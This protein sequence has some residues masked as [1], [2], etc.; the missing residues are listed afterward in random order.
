MVSVS[1]KANEKVIGHVA[2][3]QQPIIL[4]SKPRDSKAWAQ[5]KHGKAMKNKPNLIYQYQPA[6]R[7]NVFS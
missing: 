5:Q 6:R 2:N 4:L 3:Q 7:E 1:A